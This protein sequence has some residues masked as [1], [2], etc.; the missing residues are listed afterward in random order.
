MDTKSLRRQK[1]KYRIRR[2]ISGESANKPRLS[3]FR[4]NS[5]IY[6]QLI[7]DVNGVARPEEER[8]HLRIPAAGVV[9]KVNAG[10]QQLTHGER[11]QRHYTFPFPVQSATGLVPPCS[12]DTGA[13]PG[14]FAPTPHARVRS[15]FKWFPHGNR[16][17]SSPLARPWQGDNAVKSGFSGLVRYGPAPA[18]VHA[19]GITPD[20]DQGAII[21]CVQIV[22]LVA[23][24]IS[25]GVQARITGI[26]A[27]AAAIAAVDGNRGGQ[28]S[29]VARFPHD[30]AIRQGFSG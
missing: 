9:T 22:I 25:S 3:V 14:E 12:G 19:T 20:T 16:A 23:I 11:G 17:C 2:K 26:T 1:I 8:S 4:S 28:G 18:R 15:W 21:R 30:P 27:V 7:D 24:V 6:V 29:L 5:D 13:T 10:F